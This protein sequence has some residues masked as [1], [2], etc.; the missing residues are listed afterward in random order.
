MSDLGSQDDYENSVNDKESEEE[1]DNSESS[2]DVDIDEIDNDEDVED[3][4]EEAQQDLDETEGGVEESKGNETVKQKSNIYK[5]KN[6]TKSKF[7]EEV[8]DDDDDQDEE[9]DNYL[10]KFN[11]NIIK[12]HLVDFHPES[13]THNYIEIQTLTR[14]V[15]NEDGSYIEDPLHKTIPFL[16]KYEKTRVLGQRAK[17]I[18]SGSKPFVKVDKNIIDAYVIAQMEL[19]EKKIPFIIRRPLPNGASE[20]WKLSDLQLLY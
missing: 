3:D 6:T 1:I 20:Y 7:I 9:N 14:I 11:N 5:Q 10:K 13:N 15:T 17:Q 18:E 2:T 4:A 12:N 16:T 8:E 19:K